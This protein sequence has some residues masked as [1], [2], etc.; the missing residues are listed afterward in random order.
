MA[1]VCVDPESYIQQGFIYSW[2]VW[3]LLERSR[4]YSRG[5][6][7]SSKDCLVRVATPMDTWSLQISGRHLGILSSKTKEQRDLYTNQE[8]IGGGL[9]LGTVNYLGSL[10]PS[11]HRQSGFPGFLRAF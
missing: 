9:F 10:G 3:E 8:D 11:I 7:A 4:K 6:E 2:F 1:L 5:E